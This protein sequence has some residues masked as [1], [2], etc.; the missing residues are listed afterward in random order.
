M[1]LLLDADIEPVFVS[2][3]KNLIVFSATYNVL[4]NDL[5]SIAREAQDSRTLTEATITQ[6]LSKA[7]DQ[8]AALPL[9]EGNGAAA[10]Q[11][12]FAGWTERLGQYSEASQFLKSVEEWMR[13]IHKDKS[14]TLFVVISHIFER[15]LPAYHESK[16]SGK[17]FSGRLEPVRIGRRKDFWNRLTIAYRDLL[18]HEL[19]TQEKR[20]KKTTF[21]HLVTR[22]VDGF[23]ETN[24]LLFVEHSVI[25][26]WFL[27]S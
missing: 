12:E 4:L 27:L 2:E 9:F 3:C 15:I 13:G 21:E 14:D 17:P 25:R 22:F 7:V 19:L 24:G 16:R 10:I 20:A 5:V 6:L 23:E 18:F 11:A 8:V 1:N 26:Q